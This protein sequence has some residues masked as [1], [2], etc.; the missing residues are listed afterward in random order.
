MPRQLS[1]ISDQSRWLV[2]DYAASAMSAK[3]RRLHLSDC[4]HFS[5]V[6]GVEWRAPV[7]AERAL[8]KC[9]SCERKEQ[10]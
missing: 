2:R 4:P 3:P 10:P 8:P 7:G 1:P 9:A 5:D 6:C